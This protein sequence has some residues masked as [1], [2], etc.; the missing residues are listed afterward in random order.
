MSDQTT[1]ECEFYALIQGHVNVTKTSC[2]KGT[3]QSTLT[4]DFLLKT[5][6]VCVC[7]CVYTIG[8]MT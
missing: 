1:K 4:I 8:L 7:T 3:G 5:E 2:Y 6:C